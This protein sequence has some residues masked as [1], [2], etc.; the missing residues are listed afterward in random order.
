MQDNAENVAPPTR[1]FGY[2]PLA[3]GEIRLLH[4]L[5]TTTD[6]HEVE[7]ELDHFKLNK[8]LKYFALSYVW[9]IADAAY[10]VLLNGQDFGVR[11]IF[12]ML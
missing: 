3:L 4:I 1:T 8:A 5:P 7:C 10:T 6:E 9:G 11:P 12:F 2:F